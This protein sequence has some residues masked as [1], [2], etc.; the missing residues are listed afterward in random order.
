ME[1]KEKMDD[2]LIEMFGCGNDNEYVE[3][4][5][6]EYLWEDEEYNDKD[7]YDDEFVDEWNDLKNRLRNGKLINDKWYDEMNFELRGEDI[8]MWFISKG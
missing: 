5:Y 2:V 8:L 7:N 3:G 1:N 4:E 6:V